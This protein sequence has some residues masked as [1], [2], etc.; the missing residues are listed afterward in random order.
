VPSFVFWIS[1]EHLTSNGKK[2]MEH[3]KEF[4]FKTWSLKH[5]LKVGTVY[6]LQKESCC[7]REALEKLTKKEINNLD[8]SRAQKSIIGRAIHDLLDDGSR[9][10]LDAEFKEDVL[11][12]NGE[13]DAL[14]FP[15]VKPEEEEQNKV[16]EQEEDEQDK[17]N[18]EEE[19]EQ[20]KEESVPEE[21]SSS[22]REESESDKESVTQ[23]TTTSNEG[24]PPRDERVQ[25]IPKPR[26]KSAPKTMGRFFYVL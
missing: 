18:E 3:Q 2:K 13:G 15:P 8:I 24:T 5:G 17:P 6:V 7:S 19:K 21:D 20:D 22:K 4:D 9:D 12:S 23:E 26:P 1:I 10:E 25:V 16:V 14:E 11:D